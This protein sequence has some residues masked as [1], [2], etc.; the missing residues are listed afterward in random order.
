MDQDVVC[1]SIN[2]EFDS[3]CLLLRLWDSKEKT[4]CQAVRDLFTLALDRNYSSILE[5]CARYKIVEP[6][7]M[8]LDSCMKRGSITGLANLM[9]YCGVPYETLRGCCQTDDE[10]LLLDVASSLL[11]RR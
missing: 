10:N 6:T 3:Y 11:S 7:L 2:T 9:G 4:Q 8:D 5:K 1:H